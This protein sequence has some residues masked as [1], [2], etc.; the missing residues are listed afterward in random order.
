MH[1]TRNLIEKRGSLADLRP[2]LAK[3]WHPTKNGDL[4]PSD[5]SAGSDKKVWWRC[6]DCGHEWQARIGN[7][8]QGRGCPVCAPANRGARRTEARAEKNGSPTSRRPDPVPEWDDEKNVP[9][10]PETVPCGSHRTAWWIC[11]RSGF[12][13]R[14]KIYLRAVYRTGCPDCNK[15]ISILEASVFRELRTIFPQLQSQQRLDETGEVDICCPEYGF[16]IE[17]DGHQNHDTGGIALDEEKNRRLYEA[18]F[19]PVIHVRERP[20]GRDYV[21]YKTR[22]VVSREGTGKGRTFAKRIP[23]PFPSVGFS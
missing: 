17:I 23:Y 9:P 15:T 12:R 4:K 5:I 1:L 11:S 20:L 16:A 10:T 2:D 22:K 3:R 8:K 13:Y 14:N 19:N 6:P 21:L 7:G 18:G